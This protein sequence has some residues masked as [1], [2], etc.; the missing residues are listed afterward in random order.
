MKKGIVYGAFL[1]LLTAA[2]SLPA[3]YRDRGQVR[4]DVASPGQGRFISSE[5]EKLAIAFL[6]GSDVYLFEEYERSG[7]T[8]EMSGVITG[9]YVLA[10]LLLDGEDHPVGLRAKDVEITAGVNRISLTLGPGLEDFRFKEAGGEFEDLDFTDMP[11]GYGLEIRE[12]ALV[13]DVPDDLLDGGWEIRFDS[14]A[15]AGS[16]L[17]EDVSAGA[18]GSE[19]GS[20]GD[21]EVV[22]TGS[23]AGD[24]RYTSE[25]TQKGEAFSFLVTLK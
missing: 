8:V 14:N 18:A 19:S 13:F 17:V 1:V 2:C 24:F 21:L 5:G 23:G 7:G 15:K 25:D 22:I 20:D 11:E 6:D 16:V 4:I 12:D 10:V 3:D 9:E